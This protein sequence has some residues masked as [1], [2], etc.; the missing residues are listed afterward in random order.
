MRNVVCGVLCDA[1]AV[2]YKQFTIIYSSA[3]K[4]SCHLARKEEGNLGYNNYHKTL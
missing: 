3:C 4:I 2:T 1:W